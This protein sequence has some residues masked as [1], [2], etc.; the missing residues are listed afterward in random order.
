M[1]ILLKKTLSLT[2]RPCYRRKAETLSFLHV[3]LVLGV[4]MV[5]LLITRHKRE[6]ISL[7]QTLGKYLAAG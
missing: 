7:K 2:S 4:K 6:G 3:L 5:S 1:H